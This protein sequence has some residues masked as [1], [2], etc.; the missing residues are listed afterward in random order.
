MLIFVS[1]GGNTAKASHVSPN[2]NNNDLFKDH[3]PLSFD[4]SMFLS[5]VTEIELKHI[6]SK[7]KNGSSEALDW[8]FD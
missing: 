8:I 1:I 3:M 7:R 5:P 6:I 4:K 2:N